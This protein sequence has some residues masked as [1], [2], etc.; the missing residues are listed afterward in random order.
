VR[1]L[2]VLVVAVGLAA[3]PVATSFATHAGDLAGHW[4]LDAIEQPGNE[5]PDSSGHGKT[6]DVTEGVEVVA[7]RHDNAFAFDDG[8]G[9]QATTSSSTFLQEQQVTVSAWVK[10]SGDPGDLRYIVAKR[11][12]VDC[13][14]SAYAL[15]TRNG[16][17]AFYV[18]E[19][20]IRVFSPSSSGD[21]FDGEWHLV[22]GM[23]DGDQVR[24]YVDGALVGAN[25]GGT[26][27]DYEGFPDYG[28]LSIGNY[29]APTECANAVFPGAID[30]VRVY[31]RALT[32]DEVSALYGEPAP[33][34]PP[35]PAP[36]PPDGG[37]GGGAGGGAPPPGP[38]TASFS[39]R[40]AS[41]T[42][43]FALLDARGS[44]GASRL[45]WDVDGNGTDDV[46]CGG[47]EPVLA[48]RMLRA[49]TYDARLTAVAADGRTSSAT[50]ALAIAGRTPGSGIL[51]RTP[52]VTACSKSPD[53]LLTG[54]V[55]AE[56][57]H[58]GIVEAKGCMTRVTTREEVP[59][60]ERRVVD[61]Y[62]AN[63]QLSKITQ[64][65]CNKGL[66]QCPDLVAKE[67]GLDLLVARGPVTINGLRFTPSGGAAIV[68][69][70]QLQRVVSSRA[71]LSIGNVPVRPAASVDL[72]L[73][74][75]TLSVRG[76][77]TGSIR[78]FSFDAARSLPSIGGFNLTGQLDLTLRRQRERRFLEAKV[79]LALPAAFN[80][81]G[82]SPPTGGVTLTANNDSNGFILGR[83]AISVPEA[84]LG[85]I[86]LTGLSF[87][88]DASGDAEAQ[89]PRQWWKA[90][91]RVYLGSTG[92]E[93]GFD[94][95][96]PPSQNGIAFCAGGFHS[97]GGAVEFGTSLPPP[98]PF[99]GVFINR[100]GF[101]TQLDPFLLRG[102]MTVTAAQLSEVK[103][104]LF[105]AFPSPSRP[106][107]LT[108]AD[109]GT[110]FQRFANTRFVSPTFGVGGT[111]GLRVPALGTLPFGNAYFL[112][113][114][115]E[116]LAIGGGV[117]VPAPGLLL[118][119]GVDGDFRLSRG[120]F[121]VYGRAEA[122][123]AG[124]LGCIGAEAWVTNI[125]VVACGNIADELH[126]GAG[127]K[128]GEV[129]PTIWLVDGCKPSHY[130]PNL[131]ARAAQ[132][133]PTTF[134]VAE[135]ETTKNVRLGGAPEVEV[136]GPDG[137]S[138]STAD[139]DYA[140]GA[141]IKVLRQAEGNMTWIGVGP[142]KPG[143]YTIRPL[144]GSPAITSTAETRPGDDAPITVRVLGPPRAAQATRRP[145][146]LR[147]DVG[148]A[149]GRSVE[150][151][152]RGDGIL[153]P[154]GVARGARGRLRFTPTIGPAG[155]REVVARPAIDGVPAPELVVARFAAGPPPRA[156]RPGRLRVRR[157]GRTV[158]ASWR[159]AR[160]A[161]AYAVVL[162][163]RSGAQVVRELPRTAR[164]VRFR[165][166]AATQRGTVTVR[167][168]G[169]LSDW[170]RPAT[171]RFRATR[172]ARSPFR[173]FS[174]L[175]RRR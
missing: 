89:C 35:P 51:R 103:G 14:A 118:R 70:P 175:G 60:A 98:Q 81:F 156:A 58:F 74:S 140:E 127:L 110:Q 29:P 105:M 61:E 9:Q 133:A 44:A 165:G 6:L 46:E 146:T 114:A 126:P 106:Y 20:D 40:G 91:A 56:R 172:R 19:G 173:D 168:Q 48:V 21:V 69:F 167:S 49:G 77:P 76:N 144:P 138:V 88:Y 57:V 30:D 111:F 87:T 142:A 17:I 129:W 11:G 10:R 164:S 147:Y 171:A 12:D 137:E 75:Q 113:S 80:L 155:Q 121:S 86:R 42:M 65:I 151:F 116:S 161:R 157:R 92:T 43:Q 130:W 93:G 97:F 107:T 139:A 122:C 169:P 1:R 59:A 112:F 158:V 25:G 131:N 36:P 13:S 145:I 124:G 119:A 27:I 162:E 72:P 104:V 163:Q 23:L 160:N 150:F 52:D 71:A 33:P 63:L 79:N 83:L 108:T 152:E 67:K 115:P 84:H 101:A 7:G 149:E 148:E 45:R 15:V 128:W 16:G 78:L 66:P 8:S 41:S 159:R 153:R 94:F 32:G 170:S 136:R 166:I 117:T 31:G 50:Q 100:I 90:T 38:L 3:T 120:L 4:R 62:Y 24:L 39:A 34:P 99:P 53:F 73:K 37:G 2:A 135:G 102:E 154:L 95:H 82:G 85:S 141:T 26:D 134:S 22:T 54:N 47:D 5:S 123:I 132:G 28:D 55:C 174:K 109:A 64:A 143:R 18:Y 96:P 68:V 125:G